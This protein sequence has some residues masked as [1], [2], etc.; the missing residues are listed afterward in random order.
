MRVF[1]TDSFDRWLRKEQLSDR[2]L[3][4][5]AEEVVLG[6]FEADLGGYLFKKRIARQGGGKSGGYRTIIGYRR[7]STDRVIFLFG[8]AKNAEETVPKSEYRVLTAVAGSFL[9]ADDDLVKDLTLRRK[10]R[11]LEG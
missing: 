7:G 9:Q 5:A 10:V 3:W 6:R 4:I 1:V 11:E 2:A 8:F